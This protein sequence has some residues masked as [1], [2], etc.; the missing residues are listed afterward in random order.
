MIVVEGGRR[1]VGETVHVVVT[2][3]IQTS[4]GRMIFSRLKEEREG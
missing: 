2:T 4:D 1:H 3:V